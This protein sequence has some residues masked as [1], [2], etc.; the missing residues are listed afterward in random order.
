MRKSK[1]GGL[2]ATVNFK[3]F[4]NL[5]FKPRPLKEQKGRN[6]L[7]QMKQE[8]KWKGRQYSQSAPCE[9]CKPC[10]G[11]AKLVSQAFASPVIQHHEADQSGPPEL[12]S[13]NVSMS[14]SVKP[15]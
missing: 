6:K 10:Q 1:R 12:R 11:F 9:P 5:V 14:W 4:G 2:Q 15:W 8:M 13:A 7:H 3:G